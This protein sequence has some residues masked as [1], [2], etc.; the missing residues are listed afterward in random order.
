MAAEK[1]C[2][3]AS[4][5]RRYL[6]HYFG[7]QMD[8]DCGNCDNC[9]RDK[10]KR[11][12]SRESYLLLFCIKSCGG[13]WGLNMPIDI[14]R[15]S[16][17]RKIIDNNFDKLPV[18]GCGKD[19]TA[20]WWKALAGLLIAH[21]YLKEIVDDI[22]RIVSVSST[23]LQ[24]LQSANFA[25]Q[26][27]MILVLTRE[28]IDEEDHET[29]QSNADDKKGFV[30]IDREGLPMVEKKLYGVLL[31]L[32]MELAKDNGTAPYAICGDQTLIKIAKTRP[33]TRARLANIEG[34]NQHLVNSYGD[35]FLQ[36]IS[37]ASQELGLFLNEESNTVPSAKRDNLSSLKNLS[38][39]KL[40]AWKL[41][42][43]GKNTL[44]EVCALRRSVPIKEQTVISYI[45]EAAHTGC[46]VDWARFCIEIGLTLE[47]FSK[48]HSAVSKIGSRERLKLIKEELTE[49][50]T[51]EQIK[52]FLTME[53]LNI[54]ADKIFDC[55]IS[56]LL[57]NS[58]KNDK[59]PREWESL[60][61]ERAESRPSLQA[62]IDG[63]KQN[64]HDSQVHD[65]SAKKFHLSECIESKKDGLE[66][67]KDS[68]MDLTESQDGIGDL[69]GYVDDKKNVLEATKDT[70]MELIESQDGMLFSEIANYF[71]GSKA[72]G[73]AAL[74]GLLES[75]FLIF[76]KNGLYQAL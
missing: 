43:I 27:P 29:Q 46:E 39:A 44:K 53:D 75:E 38:P 69:T 15:G 65:R 32:R 21:G 16:R 45:L 6:L 31:H 61:R 41:W 59:L 72:E 52:T 67:T 8:T 70:V 47:I 51:Y 30:D 35:K 10:I 58:T 12:I 24:Y 17:A 37:N 50:V 34:V 54:C 2:L 33:S 9:T 3:L 73:V 62:A 5:R 76:K 60:V 22:Y 14:L 26:P 48:I 64:R 42:Q 20:A 74:L 36:T 13:R 18:H 55:N 66:A 4:C 1:Y 49:N 71:E 23:G 19:Y 57:K 25:I 40:E 7:E 28:M 11:D 63:R 56:S 68:V